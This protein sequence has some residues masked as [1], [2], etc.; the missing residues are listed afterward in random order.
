MITALQPC[1][2]LQLGLNSPFVK[3]GADY[4]RK[5]SAEP[6]EANGDSPS[7]KASLPPVGDLF[8]FKSAKSAARSGASASEDD[9]LP[10]MPEWLQE[11]PYLTGEH[12]M[13]ACFSL[14]HMFPPVLQYE[15]S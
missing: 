13:Q 2:V 10:A 6:G 4:W 8:D 7:K 9:A 14:K 5:E 1:F 12:L 3:S 15:C 11:R